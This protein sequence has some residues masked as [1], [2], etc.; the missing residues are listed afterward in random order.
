MTV[1]RTMARK[2]PTS[3]RA[4]ENTEKK[5]GGKASGKGTNVL[6][7]ENLEEGL[8]VHT[9]RDSQCTSS[10]FCRGAQGPRVRPIVFRKGRPYD[11][12]VIV[13]PFKTLKKEFSLDRKNDT[14]I[15]AEQEIFKFIELHYNAKRLHS[16][17]CNLSP[18]EHE[19]QYAY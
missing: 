16:S 4:P 13:S 11:N 7:R 1:Q 15:K 10:R 12:A 6:N 9:D 18:V 5:G 8:I 2:G 17:L 3:C 19:W 14:R